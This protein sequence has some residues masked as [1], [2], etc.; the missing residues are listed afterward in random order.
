MNKQ[1]RLVIVSIAGILVNIRRAVHVF[2]QASAEEDLFETL[3]IGRRSAGRGAPNFLCAVVI[4]GEEGILKDYPGKLILLNFGQLVSIFV[5]LNAGHCRRLTKSIKR[6]AFVCFRFQ[7]TV[8]RLNRAGENLLKDHRITFPTSRSDVKGCFQNLEY[9]AYLQPFLLM[10]VE[11]QLVVRARC[12]K[13]IGL[14]YGI[15]LRC[16]NLSRTCLLSLEE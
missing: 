9:A 7:L 6:K 13:R 8:G 10:Q 2:F 15:V 3:Q 12:A 11:K 1:K 14:E 16:I 4:G 5:E